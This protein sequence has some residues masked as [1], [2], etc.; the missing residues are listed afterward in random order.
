MER[1]F[2][3]LGGLGDADDILFSELTKLVKQLENEAKDTLAL[4]IKSA[5]TGHSRAS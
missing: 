5:L 2:T 3:W 1:A 4:V